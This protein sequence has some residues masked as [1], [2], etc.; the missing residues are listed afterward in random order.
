MSNT[1]AQCTSLKNLAQMVELHLHQM[2]PGATSP[3]V[4]HKK[5]FEAARY[6]LLAGGKRIRPLLCLAA[7]EILGGD[8]KSGLT[9]ACTL[10]LIHTASLIHDDLPCMDNDDFRR[11]KPTL[12]KVVPEGMALLAGDYLLA[13]AFGFLAKAPNLTAEQRIRLVEILS[14]GAGGEGMSAGQ[15]I[16][17]DEENK[18]ASIEE[19]NDLHERKTGAMIVASLLFGGVIG[20]A[21]EEEMEALEVFGNEI[22]LAFQII[23]DVLDVTSTA[24]ELGKPIGSDIRQEKITYVNFL[25][26]EGAKEAAGRSIARSLEALERLPNQG[27]QLREIANLVISRR[28]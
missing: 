27:G 8:L 23:D 18:P 17:I 16:D 13:E 1:I 26:I 25:G 19:L 10:E 3:Q 14:F 4:R 7:I 28:N 15:G 11:G 5:L 22:G 2:I 24:E 20:H 12:H 21:T 9:P 6:S